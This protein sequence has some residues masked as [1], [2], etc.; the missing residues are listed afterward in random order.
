VVGVF[1]IL[2][3]GTPGAAAVD[4]SAMDGSASPA[5]VLFEGFHHYGLPRAEN[6]A[7][8][9]IDALGDRFDFMVWYSDFRVD[10]QEAGTRS[11]GDIAQEVQGIG[12]RMDIG[13]RA[14]DYCS[15]GRLQVTWHQPVWIG[16]VQAHEGSPDGAWGDYDKAVAQIAHELGHRWS[17]RTRAIVNGDTIELRGEH[18]PWAMSGAGHPPGNLHTPSPF[19]Y[20]DG[21]HEG[22]IMGGA[23]YQ[24]NGDGTFTVLDRG[25]MQPASG[26]SYLELYLIGVLAPEDVPPFFLLTN[27]R[28]AGRD[29]QG[30]P[31]VRAE[32]ID[33]TIEDVIAHNGPRVPSF[34]D[35]PREF[36]TAFVAV[37]LPGRTPSPELLER[38]DAIRRQ[39]IT[40]WNKVTGGIATMSTGLD[41]S[42]SR[43]SGT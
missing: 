36:T 17:T 33:I 14:S 20:G 16:S 6:M 34:A 28:P 1:S 42:S 4:L 7:C 37:V 19:P 39:W 13:R 3:N 40:Y 38:T 24:D 12:P 29:G 9:V 8:T 2:E 22:S 30:R 35:A 32:R 10:D 26:F 5:P 25:S 21:E 43:A 31:M 23:V 27:P 41:A 18:V 15:D 11:D